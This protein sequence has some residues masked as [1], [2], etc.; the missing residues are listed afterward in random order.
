MKIGIGVADY[1][2][3]FCRQFDYSYIL[4]DINDRLCLY[5]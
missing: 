2:R 1:V 5:M 4:H 3:V